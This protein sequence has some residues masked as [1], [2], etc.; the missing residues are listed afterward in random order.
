[1]IKQLSENDLEL[2]PENDLGNLLLL[3]ELLYT[4]ISLLNTLISETVEI[5]CNSPGIAWEISHLSDANDFFLRSG[6]YFVCTAEGNP[7]CINDSHSQ[8]NVF[9]KVGDI[10][11]SSSMAS[12][13]LCH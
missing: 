8:T 12:S 2:L 1:M 7:G 13:W 11:S 3:I 4:S 6:P 5:S 9:S 10:N